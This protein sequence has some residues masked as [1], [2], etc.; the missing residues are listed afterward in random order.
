MRVLKTNFFTLLISVC[1]RYLWHCSYFS[2]FQF[3]DFI[4]SFFSRLSWPSMGST[5]PAAPSRNVP[6][7]IPSYTARQVE[8]S[9]Y[10]F[11]LY[12]GWFSVLKKKM[13]NWLLPFSYTT[14][15]SLTGTNWPYFFVTFLSELNWTE[16][17]TH[18]DTC[19]LCI[20]FYLSKCVLTVRLFA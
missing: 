2:C 16:P 7:N 8:A 3:P 13:Q 17:D 18:T 19:Y 11:G 10:S 9:I 6:R 1:Q 5:A 20:L 12:Y 4:A 15:H 14:R